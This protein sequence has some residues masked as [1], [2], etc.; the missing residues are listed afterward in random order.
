LN[1]FPAILALSLNLAVPSAV[2]GFLIGFGGI[3]GVLLAPALSVIGGLPIQEAIRIC[4]WVYVV[5]GVVGTAMFLRNNYIRGRMLLAL[6]AGVCPSALAGAFA[7]NWIGAPHLEILMAVVI[8]TSGLFT[9]NRL[10]FVDSGQASLNETG[11]VAIGLVTGFG[12]SLT[13]TGGALILIPILLFAHI[14]VKQALGLAQAIQVPIGVVA[15]VVNFYSGCLDLALGSLIA[16]AV[17]AGVLVG[18]AYAHRSSSTQLK[19]W[20]GLSLVLVSLVYGL[21]AAGLLL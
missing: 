3:G 8:F 21:H 17:G 14:E 4:M 12:S 1:S 5:S 18:A 15:S 20:V 2:I 16:V 11:L 9:L 13:G 7:L 6:T 10:H 19:F